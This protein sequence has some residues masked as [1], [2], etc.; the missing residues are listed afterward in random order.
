MQWDAPKN[1]PRR[2]GISSFGFGGT[3][4]HIA[5]EAY[6]A[7]YHDNLV[8]S[9]S[10]QQVLANT[11]PSAKSIFDGTAKPSM[12]HDELKSIEGGLFLISATNIDGLVTKLKNLSFEGPSFDEDPCGRR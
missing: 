5:L 10:S 7:K 9:W 1:H 2:A 3:N 6:D 11:T 12:T 8:A 4:F